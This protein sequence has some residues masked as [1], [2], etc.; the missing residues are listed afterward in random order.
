MLKRLAI[1]ILATGSLCG[2]YGLYA[3]CVTPMVQRE[4]PVVQQQ[5]KPSVVEPGKRGQRNE[6]STKHLPDSKWAW[7]AL[8]QFHDGNRYI[9]TEKWERKPETP[10]NIPGANGTKGEIEFTPFAMVVVNEDDPSEPP[11]TLVSRSAVLQFEKGFESTNYNPGRIVGGALK[12]VYEIR[13]PQGLWAR[14]RNFFF[15][16]N[17]PRNPQFANAG[18]A[19]PKAWSDDKVVFEYDGHRGTGHGLELKLIPDSKSNS[20]DKPAIAGIHTIRLR[21]HV[22][23]H[24]LKAGNRPGQPDERVQIN[25]DGPFVFDIVSNTVSF[26]EVVK[27]IRRTLEGNDTLDSDMLHIVFREVKKIIEQPA[28]EADAA[29][30][31]KKKSSKREFSRLLAT[32][33]RV[34]L[35]S[36]HNNV[37][38]TMQEL[39]YD[40]DKKQIVMKDGHRVHVRQ[41]N[42]DFYCPELTINQDENNEIISILGRGVG[43]MTSSDPDTH[44]FAYR[45]EWQ[46]QIWKRPDPK[47]DQDI[48]EFQ[49]GAR[50]LQYNKMGIEAELIRVWLEEDKAPRTAKTAR[51]DDDA[52]GA[53]RNMK[54]QRLLARTNVVFAANQPEMSGSTKKLEVWFEEGK[55]PRIDETALTTPAPR[56]RLVKLNYQRP[57]KRQRRPSSRTTLAGKASQPPHRLTSRSRGRGQALASTEDEISASALDAQASPDRAAP[58]QQLRQPPA[59]DQ[60]PYLIDADRIQIRVIRE[61]EEHHVSEVRTVGHVSIIQEHINGDEPLTIDCHKMT[62]LNEDQTND[63]QKI[64][65]QGTPADEHTPEIRAHLRDK[66]MHVEGLEIFTNRRENRIQVGGAG[67]MQRP[68]A[69][70]LDGQELQTPELLTVWWNERMTFDGLHARFY[71]NVRIVLEDSELT[72][73]QMDVELT[74]RISLVERDGDPRQ[75]AEI[76]KVICR[77]GVRMDS[78]QFEG[79]LLVG[80]HRGEIFELA[81]NQVTG[82]MTSSGGGWM[83]S[84]RRD[85]GKGGALGPGISASSNRSV[86]SADVQEW[87]YTKITFRGHMTG[88]ISS[89]SDSNSAAMT[90]FH[91]DV[92]VIYGPVKRPTQVID[93]DDL[94][95]MGGMLESD[96]LRVRRLPAT[97]QST[98]PYITLLATGNARLDG[99]KYW[100]RADEVTY[101]GSIGQYTLRTA[102]K[103]GYAE[104]GV[105]ERFQGKRS[106]GSKAQQFIVNEL[107]GE[108]RIINGASIGG[109]Y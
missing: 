73:G 92:V 100:G 9:F 67:L 77:D 44:Q 41:K 6:I 98:K 13:G 107:T 20:R 70:R 60:E 85:N 89:F 12:G 42:N 95:E 49:E 11:Y 94:P 51:G 106:A 74:N 47:S 14:G 2:A 10:S 26:S 37:N 104:F 75:V 103:K 22:E 91:D 28:E 39:T 8:Y 109:G 21:D 93:P 23:M 63:H 53:S 36:Q 25:S 30:P 24:L 5:V 58:P 19:S 35:K 102:P 55:I 78:K 71:D 87:K 105:R 40:G 45:A 61:G 7:D 69:N 17:P 96:T 99:Q 84:W 50:L 86:R 83:E 54:I 80:T 18:D 65:I 4:I 72:C 38:A 57:Q 97:N 15:Q 33:K 31:R 62:I 59:N 34:L 29:P 101:D 76:R 1:T 81:M 66:G 48:L 64:W 90:K 108:G 56:E 52:F 82:E 43:F 46:K 16:E 32:G 88:N 27:V 3:L 79:N 68:V